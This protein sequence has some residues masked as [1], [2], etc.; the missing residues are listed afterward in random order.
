MLAVLIP[1]HKRVA[2]NAVMDLLHI[3]TL[4]D[5]KFVI[6]PFNSLEELFHNLKKGAAE[7]KTKNFFDSVDNVLLV[8]STRTPLK[9][10]IPSNVRVVTWV[11]DDSENLLDP[12]AREA[13]NN[14][15]T[16]D[17][18]FGYMQRP[19]QTGFDKK[20]L[21]PTPFILNPGRLRKINNTVP[22][23][24]WTVTFL[25]H[26]NRD[27]YAEVLPKIYYK[28]R[29]YGI[30]KKALCEATSE[31][32]LF[33]RAKQQPPTESQ[34]KEIL[35]KYNIL[36]KIPAEDMR[37]RNTLIRVFFHWWINDM[38]FRKYR[39][40]KLFR[41]VEKYKHIDIK[42]IGDNWYNTRHFWKYAL[43]ET[44]CTPEEAG[45]YYRAGKYSLHLSLQ[46]TGTHHRI[47]EILLS[48]GKPLICGPDYNPSPKEVT[49]DDL[50]LLYQ[51]LYQELFPIIWQ[52]A[53]DKEKIK[54]VVTPI[55]K[56]STKSCSYS[57]STEDEAE[58][59]L[60]GS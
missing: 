21:I 60:L 30:T 54:K 17:L 34:I 6:L 20:R 48:G 2:Y 38:L 22:K 57:Y 9:S 5:K 15:Y 13:F 40:K 31:I 3:T 59:L 56:L 26:K 14:V 58:N 10:V 29:H 33:H 45:D 42:L 12:E 44:G 4:P 23:N 32:E 16:N 27:V 41:T 37:T 28:Y 36:T 46:T 49:P 25:S 51:N 55:S 47:H 50:T 7:L 11:Q 1:A 43:T 52:R 35:N 39:L 19:I 18:M 53:P 24:Y 8:N